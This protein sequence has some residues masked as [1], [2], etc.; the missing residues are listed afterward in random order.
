ME[1][2][3]GRERSGRRRREA[4]A[5]AAVVL[6]IAVFYYGTIRP[7]FAWRS[8]DFSLYVHHAKNLVEGRPYGATGYILNP[9][10]RSHGPQTYPPVFPVLLTPAYLLFG[11]DL[12]PMKAEVVGFFVLLLVVLYLSWRREVGPGCALAAVAVVG[13]HPYLWEMKDYVLPDFVFTLFVFSCGLWIDWLY[14]QPY[15]RRAGPAPALV[16]GA[17]LWVAYGTRNA[18]VALL[19]TLIL[20]DLYRSRRLTRFAVYAAAVFVALAAVQG[21]LFRSEASY[22]AALVVDPRVL[23]SNTSTYLYA[24][25]QLWNTGASRLGA[26]AV[27]LG[28]SFLA[29]LG[30]ARR[31]RTGLQFCEVFVLPYVVMLICWG[32]GV[33]YLIPVVPCYVLLAIYGAHVVSRWRRTV[34]AAVAVA[35]IAT[36]SATYLRAEWSH[37]GGTEARGFAELASQIKATTGPNEVFLCQNARLLSLYTDR[38]ASPYPPAEVEAIWRYATRIGARYLVFNTVNGFDR[39]YLVPLLRTHPADL[40]RRFTSGHFELYAIRRAGSPAASQLE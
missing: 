2:G 26:A 10:F 15:E 14:R 7:G 40:E 29:L 35:V 3:T 21:F 34:I 22:L 8:G 20:Y 5:V 19:P 24:T 36:Y 1:P 32:G 16:T 25:Y 11:L 33:R 13:M 27:T 28:M 38:P 17:M 18:G 23:V 9:D 4:A 12:R 30:L 6:A 37:V 39:D 31:L